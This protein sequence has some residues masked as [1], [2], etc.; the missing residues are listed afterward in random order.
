MHLT[1]IFGRYIE[2]KSFNERE[3][4]FSFYLMKEKN[5]EVRR[6]TLVCTLFSRIVLVYMSCVNK[7]NE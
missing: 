5:C 7:F 1:A 6:V 3:N 2:K 4:G